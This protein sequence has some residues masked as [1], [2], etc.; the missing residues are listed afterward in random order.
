LA[1]R[2]RSSGGV[3]RALLFA[4]LAATLHRTDHAL[5][6]LAFHGSARSSAVAVKWINLKGSTKS[7]ALPRR[8]RSPLNQ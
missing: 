6:P 5:D 4:L 8:R 2:R 7:R 3:Q 1:D